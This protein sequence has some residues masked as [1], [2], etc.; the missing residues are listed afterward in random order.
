MT[1]RL[2]IYDFSEDTPV[3]FTWKVGAFF[4]RPFFDKIIYAKNWF[5]CEN[6]LKALTEK[7][8][9]VQFWG[10]GSPGKIYIG[11]QNDPSSFW[12]NLEKVLNKD[13]TVWLRVC[14]F[15]HG[16]HGKV[17]MHIL[18]EVLGA[19]LIAHTY[20]IGTWA[21]QSGM[22]AVDTKNNLLAEWPDEEG[23][24]ENVFTSSNPLAPNTVSAFRMFAPKKVS[25][26]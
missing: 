23:R 19:R 21:S 8:D 13:A 12:G 1:K 18:S 25:N 9:E 11:G 14:S 17:M 22:H 4:G 5:D 26:K 3:G 24:K 10:H 16:D 2:M 6:Q 20:V 7:Y 15:A